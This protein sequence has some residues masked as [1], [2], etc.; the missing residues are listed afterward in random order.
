MSRRQRPKDVQIVAASREPDAQV[1]T[2]SW[3]DTAY[4][5]AENAAFA[6]KLRAGLAC[7]VMSN[8]A[9]LAEAADKYSQ[10]SPGER[11]AFS[12][13]VRAYAVSA[14]ERIAGGDFDD[15]W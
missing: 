8:T 2:T 6:D 1:V 9:M 14:M 13:I 4:A 10:I 3:T 7:K 15:R 5:L 11:D 12:F